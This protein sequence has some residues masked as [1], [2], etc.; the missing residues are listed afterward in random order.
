MNLYGYSPKDIG[1]LGEKVAREYLR[2]QGFSILGTNVRSTFGELDI[3]AKIEDTLS[4]VEVKTLRCNEFPN[5]HSQHLYDPGE[6][7]HAHKI[8]NVARMAEWYAG[9]S[10]W[11]G[12]WQ[13]DGALVWLRE[14]DGMAR[15][16]YYPQIL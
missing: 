8:R 6:N 5:Q 15:I 3:V 14:R 9:T 1:I 11:D 4:F 2:R 13:V 16:R 12:E 7:L 10:G